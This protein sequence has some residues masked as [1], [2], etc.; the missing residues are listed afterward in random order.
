MRKNFIRVLEHIKESNI[1][2]AV[3]D[4]TAH[5]SDLPNSYGWFARDVMPPLST[6]TLVYFASSHNAARAFDAAMLLEKFPHLTTFFMAAQNDAG[7]RSLM[8]LADSFGLIYTSDTRA[9]CR[10]IQ[11]DMTSQNFDKEAV[12]TALAAGAMRKRDDG[13]WTQDGVFSANDTDR[14]SLFLIARMDTERLSGVGADFGCG[15]GELT[16]A[17]LQKNPT[18]HIHALDYDARA[19]MCAQKNLDQFAGRVTCLRWDARDE[20]CLRDLDFILMNPPFHTGKETSLDLGQVFFRRARESLKTNGILLA[21]A[22][23]H[24]AYEHFCREIFSH[25][26]ITATNN[27]FK[28]LKCVA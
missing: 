27:Q 13:L 17:A 7:G 20:T 15:I 5:M 25:V 3:F 10:V 11:V 16:Y 4:A 23:R 18:L 22:N 1:V 6:R 28:I 24:L 26:E 8:K 9:H 19:V 12:K 21:V 2:G 14:G